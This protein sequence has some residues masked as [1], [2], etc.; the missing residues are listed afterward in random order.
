[1][2]FKTY[3]LQ[4]APH[5]VE[6][7]QNKRLSF[8]FNNHGRFIL[9]S[10]LHEKMGKP[11]GIVILQDTQYPSDF[12]LRASTDPA[13]FRLKAGAHNQVT[14]RSNTMAG[15]ISKELKLTPPYSVRFKVAEKEDGLYAIATK[16]PIIKKKTI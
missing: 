3:N 13:A 15:I 6:K 8:S 10:I 1:M 14:F 9:G 11:A 16:Q 4:N 12:Y 7:K 2:N 5:K